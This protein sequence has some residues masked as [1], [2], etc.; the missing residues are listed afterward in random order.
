MS[1]NQST[2]KPGFSLI[3]VVIV[4]AIIAIITT[5]AMPKFASAGAGRRLQAAINVLYDDIEN[6]QLRARATSKTHLIKFYPAQNQYVIVEGDEV[7]R[8]SVVLI[9]DF[10]DA[11]YELNLVSTDLGGDEILV[12]TPYGIL[13]P[14][15]NID[16]SE[17]GITKRISF[18]GINADK[19]AVVPTLTLKVV[20]LVDLEVKIGGL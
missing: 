8:E 13:S 7:R 14:S 16:I 19:V 20:D 15:C 4:V 12:V 5:I 1:I 17:E 11:P 18:E 9:R 6:A 3:E 10:D 2:L